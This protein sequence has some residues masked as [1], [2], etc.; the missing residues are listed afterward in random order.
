MILF[1]FDE[2]CRSIATSIIHFVEYR[3]NAIDSPMVN[4]VFELINQ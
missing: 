2:A 1:Y 4:D 3:S